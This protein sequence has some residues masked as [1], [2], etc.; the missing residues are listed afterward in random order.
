MVMAGI[1]NEKIMGRREKKSLRSALSKI[2][3]VEKKNQP[4]IIKNMDITI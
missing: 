2:K 3:K 4:V 1:I